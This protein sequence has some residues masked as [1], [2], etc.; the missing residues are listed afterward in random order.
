MANKPDTVGWLD[1]YQGELISCAFSIL[2][3]VMYAIS[4]TAKA[5]TPTSVVMVFVVLLVS[6]V[7]VSAFYYDEIG[8]SLMIALLWSFA[9]GVAEVAKRGYLLN[10]GEVIPGRGKTW[11]FFIAGANWSSILFF[12]LLL[13]MP[14][15]TL[16]GVML[17]IVI[18]AWALML[19]WHT[20]GDK[21]V[22][23]SVLRGA[24]HGVRLPI[25]LIALF[26]FGKL[27]VLY[28]PL[29][30]FG[31][32]QTDRLITLLGI[33][34]TIIFVLYHDRYRTMPR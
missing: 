28:L 25:A 13:L 23:E 2:L 6:A 34:L 30:P 1:L 11:Q 15:L 33:F 17:C 32:H 7:L 10:S 3:V 29:P 27:P 31:A 9:L 12:N 4:Y 20:I 8:L 16:N 19:S 26:L 5:N 22:C 21:N 14:A 24:W 18:V